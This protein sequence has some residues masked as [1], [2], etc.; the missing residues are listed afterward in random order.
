MEMKKIEFTREQYILMLKLVY[1]GRWMASSHHDEPDKSLEEIEQYI[2]SYAKSFGY[3]DMVDFDT[4]YKKYYPSAELEEDLDPIISEYDDNTF[5]DELAWRMAERDFSQKY[6]EAQVL[7]MTSD[8][9]FRE[10]NIL[11]DKY[12]DEFRTHGIEHVNFTK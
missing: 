8:E 3:D 11:A 2:Y 1:L 10:K 9:I 5:W 6:D 4:N 12:F 7:C